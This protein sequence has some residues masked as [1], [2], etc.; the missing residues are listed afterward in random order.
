M[1]PPRSAP[2]RPGAQSFVAVAEWS[3]GL[4]V[5]LGADRCCLLESTIRRLLGRLDPDRFDAAIGVFVQRWCAGGAPAGRRQRSQWMA[6][7]CA[8]RVTS[9]PMVSRSPSGSCSW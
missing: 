2:L 5:V 4:A 6:R 1:F 8:A 7:P 3:S 9:A